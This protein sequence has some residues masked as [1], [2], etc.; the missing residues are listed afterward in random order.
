[1]VWV[2]YIQVVGVVLQQLQV[3][4]CDVELVVLILFKGVDVFGL[5]ECMVWVDEIFGCLV[6]LGWMICDNFDQ[7]ICIGWIELMLEG[8]MVFVCELVRFELNS[9]QCELVQDLSMCYFIRGL[10]EEL[11]V[12]EQKLLVLCGEQVVC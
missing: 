10:V 1:M 2:N 11:Q 6:E 12:S 8:C 3:D 9:D 4:V 7:L 5:C